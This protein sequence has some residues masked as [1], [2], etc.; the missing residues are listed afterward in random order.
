M[1]QTAWYQTVWVLQQVTV[2]KGVSKS[3]RS[4][5]TETSP[6]NP[7]PHIRSHFPSNKVLSEEP[8]DGPDFKA[9][10]GYC[11]YAVSKVRSCRPPTILFGGGSEALRRCVQYCNTLQT[12]RK[13][14][15]SLRKAQNCPKLFANRAGTF[16]QS[17]TNLVCRY[18]ILLHGIAW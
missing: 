14:E 3:H 16:C 15:D 7:N 10:L 18:C 8:R 5:A 9:S 12:V 13:L 2:H 1:F 4:G 11:N 17:Q 6:T